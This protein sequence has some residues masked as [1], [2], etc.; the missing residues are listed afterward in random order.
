M[1]TVSCQN[2]Q[3]DSQN[4]YTELRKFY[5]T[6]TNSKVHIDVIPYAIYKIKRYFY[7]S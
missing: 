2:E 1:N 5:C 4:Q 6:T 3:I 7:V